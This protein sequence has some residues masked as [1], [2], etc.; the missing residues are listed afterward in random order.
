[1]PSSKNEASKAKVS[2]A[3]THLAGFNTFALDISGISSY[4]PL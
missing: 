3:A 4:L 2:I 1:M